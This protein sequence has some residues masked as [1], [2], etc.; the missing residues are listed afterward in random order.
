MIYF[1]HRSIDSFCLNGIPQFYWNIEI[2]N[3]KFNGY[4]ESLDDFDGRS[5]LKVP[6]EKKS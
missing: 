6:E 5:E 4:A 1:R 3:L 2:M